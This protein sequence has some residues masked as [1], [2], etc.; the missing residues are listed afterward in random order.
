MIPDK[1]RHDIE[2]IARTEGRRVK[3]VPTRGDA[4][5]VAHG[6]LEAQAALERPFGGG[7]VRSGS[8]EPLGEVRYELKRPRATDAR[9]R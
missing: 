3:V 6:Q 8:A 9:P 2:Q 7:G 1:S 4:R 5:D